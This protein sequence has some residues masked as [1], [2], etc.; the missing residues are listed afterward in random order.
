MDLKLA[1]TLIALSLVCGLVACDQASVSSGGPANSSDSTGLVN[2]KSQAESLCYGVSL[3]IDDRKMCSGTVIGKRLI[4][5][6]GHCFRDVRPGSVTHVRRTTLQRSGRTRTSSVAKVIN[7]TIHPLYLRGNKNFDLA[8]LYTD[9]DLSENF[10]PVALAPA[11]WSLSQ[12]SRFIFV[13]AGSQS[14]FP[15]LHRG[16]YEVQE[17]ELQGT[18]ELD[19]VSFW[20]WL[21]DWVIATR[22]SE[23]DGINMSTPSLELPIICSGDSGGS[24]IERTADGRSRLIGVLVSTS[25]MTIK[26]Q[27]TCIGMGMR[28]LPVSAHLNWIRAS[29]H[30]FGQPL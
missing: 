22:A 14:I 16:E 2:G 29:A 13:G 28:A 17:G 30:S 26:G 20:T 23:G 8:L 24:L 10:T 25:V 1:S 9:R 5:G 18:R 11:D 12:D 21:A 7:W 15:G 27:E 19:R 4:L 6:A 3:D